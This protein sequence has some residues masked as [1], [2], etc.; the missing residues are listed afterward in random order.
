MSAACNLENTCPLDRAGGES[1]PIGIDREKAARIVDQARIAASGG[2]GDHGIATIEDRRVAAVA[3]VGECQLAAA[4]VRDGGV[5]GIGGVEELDDAATVVCDPGVARGAVIL[6]CGFG[7]RVGDGGV[8][9]GTIVGEKRGADVCIG[10]GGVAGRA[11]GEEED[12]TVV[13]GDG[14]VAGGGGVIASRCTEL[15]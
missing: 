2:V 5:P 12:V 10:D 15:G 7:I 6:E 3:A 1:W 9:G 13:I 11:R 8:A 14:G 4:V